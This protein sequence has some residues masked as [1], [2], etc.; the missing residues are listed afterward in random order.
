MKNP[1]EILNNYKGQSLKYPALCRI[2][3][4]EQKSGKGKQYHINKIEQ[5][6]DLERQGSK[7]Y[8]RKIYDAE[9]ELQIIEN[10]GKFTS[11]LRQFMINLFWTIRQTSPDQN[12]IILT[13]RDILEQ[14]CMVN[15]HYFIG[16]S[17][18]YKYIN[19][20]NLAMNPYDI[21]SEGYLYNKILDESEIFFSSSYRLL[22][23]IV[24][25]SLAALENKSLIIKDRTFRLY[26]N[27]T[28]SFGRFVSKQHD[29]TEE[30]KSTILTIQHKSVIE[31]NENVERD[32]NG[33]KKYYLKNVQSAHYLY[34]QQQKEFYR[35]LNHNVKEAFKGDG[36]NAYSAA[37]KI[38]LAKSESFDYEMKNISYRQLNQN[39][40]KK[41]LTAKDL[42]V[43]E[44]TLRKQFV[45]MFIK[46]GNSD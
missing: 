46:I 7:I 13:N 37:W 16:R 39:V 36:W 43:I 21:P 38:T 11:Y 27:S 42:Q 34:P 15:Q 28:D 19:E 29:C 9:D 24:Y 25:D 3:G 12:T 2:I 23:R 44:D 10:H 14:A 35:I 6:V 45:N 1:Y 8:I 32:K 40:Q 41:L 33:R 31:F 30:E 17:S 22:K 5:Y 4:E 20:I 18:P 26:N